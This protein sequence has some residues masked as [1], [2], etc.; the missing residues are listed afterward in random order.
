MAGMHKRRLLAAACAL[1]LAP[2]WAQQG[3]PQR[4]DPRRDAQA[5]VQQALAIAQAERKRVLVDVGGEWCAWCHILDRFIAAHPE[6][7]RTLDTQYVRVKVNFSPQNRN[8]QLLAR[9]PKATGYPHLYVLDAS[10]QM[11]ASQ[12]SAEL[13]AGQDY[14]EHKV[15]AF[16]RRHAAP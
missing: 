1:L 16:L 12:A 4:F 15:L 6:V 11:L 14:D 7:Q 2:A 13:E 9:W 3:L 5:D 8:A 10:G